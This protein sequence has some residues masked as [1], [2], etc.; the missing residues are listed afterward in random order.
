MTVSGSRFVTIIIAK[1][2]DYNLFE[3]LK[4]SFTFYIINVTH[5]KRSSYRCSRPGQTQSIIG[6]IIMAVTH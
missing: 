3:N 4:I 5:Y 1:N 6:H 2:D